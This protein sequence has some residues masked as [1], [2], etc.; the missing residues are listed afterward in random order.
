MISSHDHIPYGTTTF[1]ESG[2]L[3]Y[4]VIV[5]TIPWNPTKVASMSSISLILGLLF[6]IFPH[7]PKCQS[8]EQ[9][10]RQMDFQTPKCRDYF[11]KT[12]KWPASGGLHKKALF[13]NNL[14][15]I[16]FFKFEWCLLSK[17]LVSM[18]RCG[19]IFEGFIPIVM[20]E[21]LIFKCC[22]PK[23]S[24]MLTIIVL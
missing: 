10:R 3:P 15:I 24:C 6:L 1:L 18:D 17:S 14:K 23:F 5:R 19:S 8:P 20:P 2:A 7:L 4:Q 16:L 22:W 12:N 21:V 9:A 11:M 13:Y